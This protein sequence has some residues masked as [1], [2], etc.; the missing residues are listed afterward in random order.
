M[1][2]SLQNDLGKMLLRILPSMFLLTHGIPKL[3]RLLNGDFGFADPIGIGELPSL[4]LAMIAEVVCPILIIV[5][6]KTRWA[7]IPVVIVMAVAGFIVH[8]SDPFKGKEMAFLYLV[9]FLVVAL[10]GPGKFS[11][12]RK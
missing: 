5:G 12:D 7:S 4:F 3:Q 2:N 10:I 6:Y 8:H 1:K 9:C 11:L